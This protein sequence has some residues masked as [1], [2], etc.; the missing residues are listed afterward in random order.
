MDEEKLRESL[1]HW[2]EGQVKKTVNR[3][4]EREETFETLSDIEVKRLYTPLDT[5]DSDYSEQL[6]FPGMYPFTRG[7]QPT[8]YRGRFWTM[9]QYSGFG[10]SKETNARIKA[11]FNI[12]QESAI[13]LAVAVGI[14]GIVAARENEID[15]PDRVGDI[16]G[17]VAVDIS[18]LNRIGWIASGKNI[19]Y[20]IDR[21]ADIYIVLAVSVAADN[22][23]LCGENPE[24]S[25]S[26][27]AKIIASDN[28]PVI[29]SFIF[30]ILSG[31]IGAFGL[32]QTY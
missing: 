30:Q 5:A 2:E 17:H 18:Y 28:S 14:T 23:L 22:R 20:H 27:I 24:W 11:V 1:L 4:P 9:R 32:I 19:I 3:F 26:R 29:D 6:G 25:C 12:M 7:V 13:R 21:V 16:H 10:T 15:Y 31:S 8:M